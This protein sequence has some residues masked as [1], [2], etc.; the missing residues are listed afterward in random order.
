MPTLFHHEV[1]SYR[2]ELKRLKSDIQKIAKPGAV[3]NLTHASFGVSNRGNQM[4]VG[5][6]S[7]V[8]VR[9]FE[10]AEGGKGGKSPIK[11]S[12]VKGQGICR[13]K[14]FLSRLGIVDFGR[15]KKWDGFMSVY[16]LRNS[17]IHS[18]GGMIV[19]EPS[20]KLVEHLSKLGLTNIL[21]GGR[22]IRLGPDALE[23]ILNIV[24]S[25]LA[26]LTAYDEER[27]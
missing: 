7:L 24:D 25:L 27:T 10:L 19:D 18:Y 16:E 21:I 9:S 1:Q 5:L 3:E 26:E 6:C 20:P 17:I 12:D 8:E 4:V 14:L 13:L 22:R 11:L 2:A 23:I 15:L